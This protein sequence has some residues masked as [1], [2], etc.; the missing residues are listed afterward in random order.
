V[1]GSIASVG[2][3]SVSDATVNSF[4]TES[5]TP[6]PAAAPA[7]INKTLA[8]GLGLG[9]GLG[10]TLVFIGAFFLCRR[11]TGYSIC[12]MPVAADQRVGET[13]LSVVHAVPIR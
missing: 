1:F 10:L 9:L 2:S 8:L 4:Y 7:T 6:Q 3:A 12:S 11:K 5:P 13:E